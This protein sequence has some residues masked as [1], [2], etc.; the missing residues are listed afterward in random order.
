MLRYLRIAF[1]A[2]CLI[3]CVLLIVLWMRSYSWNEGVTYI[4]S[5]SSFSIF[6]SAH[7]TFYYHYRNSWPTRLKTGVTFGGNSQPRAYR[8]FYW[9]WYRYAPS[10]PRNQ[11]R[12]NA[13]DDSIIERDVSIYVPY[14]FAVVLSG[15]LSVTS[16]PWVRWRFSL[17]T[18]LITTTLVAM[19][20][21]LFVWLS[22]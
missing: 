1:S 3:A 8:G 21:G 7:G 10:L 16:A 13:V 22:R 14:W 4:D 9:D 19:V 6:G 17:R 20:L 11:V 5:P 15:A 2:T 18:L 12:M